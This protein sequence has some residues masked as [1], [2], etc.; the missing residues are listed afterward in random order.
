[1]AARPDD[2]IAW[3]DLDPNLRLT[4]AKRLAASVGSDVDP[5]QWWADMGAASQ[6][7]W[8]WQ[9]THPH[10]VT[11]AY[12]AEVARI[13]NGADPAATA[14]FEELYEQLEL[15]IIDWSAI[16]EPVDDLVDGLVIPGR[17][18]QL[19]AP[20]KAGK[21]SLLVFTA[22]ELAEGRSPFDG[23][24]TPPVPVVYLDGEMGRTDLQELIEACGHDPAK[25]TNLYCSE[26][27]VRLDQNTS[28]ELLLNLVDRVGAKVVV[29]DGLN[30][31]VSAGASDNDDSTWK[32]LFIETVVPLKHRGVAVLSGDNM[33]KDLTRGSRGS[34]VKN[35]KADGVMAISKTEAGIKLKLVYGRAGVY[36]D[37]LLLDAEGH[38]RSR[39]IRYWRTAGGWPAGTQDMVR[40]L[41]SLGVTLDQ[42]RDAVRRLLKAKVTELE[43]QDRD[44][45]DYKA[46]ND[47]L[48]AALRW[49]RA[50][51]VRAGKPPGPG[52][53]QAKNEVSR[54]G[55][56]D[57]TGEIADD[58][59]GQ[60]FRTGSDSFP[61][62]MALSPPPL[63]GDRPGSED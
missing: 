20:A 14:A 37:E 58:L 56:R 51:L 6:R 45:S 15:P 59:E 60:L 16:H 13:T 43:S 52:P 38:D 40:V 50:N 48:T 30:S 55:R 27:R 63:G 46:G 7:E 41:D 31:F 39:P 25:L 19:I 53:G 35:D 5:A 61:T 49:R 47:V 21:S 24:A 3:A 9:E 34:S 11:E 33:G 22:I 4:L 26:E 1:M 44:A 62:P 54:T 42:G 28:A 18:T 2:L 23:T 36:P 17:W 57:R 12:A 29:F 8:I 32:P 10:E